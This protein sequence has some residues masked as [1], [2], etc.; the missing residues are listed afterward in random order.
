MIQ[1]GRSLSASAVPGAGAQPQ[2]AVAHLG[3]PDG[4]GMGLRAFTVEL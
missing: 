3:E 2:G 4:R 1:S